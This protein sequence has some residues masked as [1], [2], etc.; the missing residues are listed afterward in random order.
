MDL[1]LRGKSALVCASSTGLGRAVVESMA[2][3]GVHVA[4]CARREDV[5]N[6]AASSIH[7]KTGSEIFPV[8][9]DVTSQTDVEKMI[10]AIR[11]RW[12]GL[13]ILVNNAGGPPA[14]LFEKHTIEDW[15]R[16]VEL[17]F[18]SVVRLCQLVIPF[19]KEQH[20]GRI[21]NI[22]S[23]T[24]KQPVDGLILSNAVRAAV[25]GL[26]KT[27]ANELGSYGI[28][29]NNVCPGYTLTERLRQIAVSQAV[30]GKSPE[31]VYRGWEATIPLKRLAH[32]SEFASLVTFLA[33]ER[34][35]YITGATIPV[36][37]GFIKSL[38]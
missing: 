3:E 19:M 14:G 8:V 37:G 10:S 23:M 7:Q 30:D 38:L 6:E 12:G 33:S 15:R 28:L 34:A 32:P 13:H 9:A 36:D 29:V 20:W 22:T 4:M 31:E 17:N 24:V 35:S 16:A 18:V 21:I 5:L 1:G 27:L 2:L 11:R 26:A 25:A